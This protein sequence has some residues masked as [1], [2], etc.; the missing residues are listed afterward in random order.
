MVS[1]AAVLR[2]RDLHPVRPQVAEAMQ[3]QPGARRDKEVRALEDDE[4]AHQGERVRAAALGG[5]DARQVHRRGA[6]RRRRNQ[7]RGEGITI[8]ETWILFWQI[9]PQIRLL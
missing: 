9:L 3:S 2:Q 1:P 4:D 7:V 8:S 5:Q 6:R